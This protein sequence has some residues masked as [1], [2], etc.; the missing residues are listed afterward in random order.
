MRHLGGRR[1]AKVVLDELG[2][3]A[4]TVERDRRSRHRGHRA[5]LQ[6]EPEVGDFVPGHIDRLIHEEQ[7]VLHRRS[8]R[9]RD[10]DQQDPDTDMGEASRPGGCGDR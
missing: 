5:L 1:A 6:G 2:F 7:D 10:A 8:H 4:A 9:P 3:E